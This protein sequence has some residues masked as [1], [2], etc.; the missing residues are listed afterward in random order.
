MLCDILINENCIHLL[1]F[2]SGAELRVGVVEVGNEELK[3]LPVLHYEMQSDQIR[4]F[5]FKLALD[6]KGKLLGMLMSIIIDTT[7]VTIAYTKIEA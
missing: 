3:M 5:E 6:E 7:S 4:S 1:R 2:I